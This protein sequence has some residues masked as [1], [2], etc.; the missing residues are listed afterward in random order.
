MT[1]CKSVVTKAHRVLCGYVATLGKIIYDMIGAIVSGVAGLGSALFGASQ[2]RKAAR[3]Q[4][5]ETEKKAAAT[6]AWYKRN[7]YQ[8]YLNTAAAQNAVQRYKKAWEDNTAQARARQAV[9]GGTPE[10]AQAVAEAGG[11]AMGNLMGNLAAQGEQNRQAIDAQKMQMDASLSNE[12]AAIAAA[13]EA[14]AAN[15]VNNGIGVATS[16]LGGLEMGQ[17]AQSWNPTKIDESAIISKMSPER[18]AA[19]EPKIKT[20]Y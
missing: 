7:Y 8:D 12:R 9:T 18:R 20:N 3:E 1:N 10:Q 16:A 13:E 5:R 2:Q 11:E 19:L 15:L 17:K 14:A 6:A 4:R